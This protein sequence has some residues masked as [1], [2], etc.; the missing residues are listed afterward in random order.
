R[1]A[2]VV[3]IASVERLRFALVGDAV[4]IDVQA[5]GRGGLIEED[6]DS[7]A[8][9]R[10]KVRFPIA[11]QVG[12]KEETAV[13]SNEVTHGI[14][15]GAIT[16]VQEHRDGAEAGNCR[17]EV[18]LAVEVEVAGAQGERAAWNGV[19]DGAPES[20]VALVEEDGNALGGVV[21]RGKIGLPVAAQIGNDQRKG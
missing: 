16:L 13:D 17:D 15:E 11:L 20:P 3:G 10:D 6:H 8:D 18:K 9:I 7:R 4:L 2:V 19:A 1:F 12:G 21:R 14:L 5:E